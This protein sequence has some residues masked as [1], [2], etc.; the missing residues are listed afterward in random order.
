MGI[1]EEYLQEVLPADMEADKIARNFY[2]SFKNEFPRDSIMKMTLD[3]FLFA[4]EG[5][6]YDKTFC[7]QLM[8]SPLASMGNSFPSIFGL[9]LKGG[10]ELKLSGTYKT[11]GMDSARAFH[12]IKYSI[13][14]LL[15]AAE[16]LDYENIERNEL[17]S[18]FKNILMAVYFPTL[19]LPAP[20]T[21][22]LNAY[23]EALGYSFTNDAGMAYRNHTLVEWMQNTPECSGWDSFVL[24]RFCDWMWRSGKKINGTELTQN[25]INAK[26][27]EITAEL[28]KMD[29]VGKYKEAVTKVRVNQG[30]FRD[31][32]INRFDR[33]CLCGVSDIQLLTASHIKPWAV[34]EPAEKLDVDNGFLMCPNHDRLFD[35][36][37][38]TFDE[39]G[40]ILVSSSMRQNDRLFMNVSENMTIPLT[41][42]NKKYLSYHRANIFRR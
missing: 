15:E 23:C 40:K 36:G 17:N 31:R 37:F 3:S 41:E 27:R 22:A 10:T 28:D 9:Y 5:F 30:E 14:R 33:C 11:Y 32:L 39:D 24:M 1:F 42:G 29:L 18:T 35:Q 7:R 34:S 6:G 2:N 12:D 25:R 21:T 4:P 8:Y 13:I 38:I 16:E 26:V 19:Y 20:T